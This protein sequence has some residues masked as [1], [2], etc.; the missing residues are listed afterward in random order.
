MLTSR[1]IHD[2][3]CTYPAT[4]QPPYNSP[5]SVFTPALWRLYIGRQR[6]NFVPYLCQLVLAAI[7]WVELL[8]MFVTLMSLKYALSAGWW[9]CGHFPQLIDY[10]LFEWHGKFSPINSTHHAK[11]YPQNGDRIAII[12]SVTS[13]YRTL[14]FN[15]N[16][17][18][19]ASLCVFLLPA[20]IFSYACSIVYFTFFVPL[21]LTPLRVRLLRA[22]SKNTQKWRFFSGAKCSR[23][24]QF[25]ATPANA[26]AWVCH[27]H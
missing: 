19:L 11:L 4:S 14:F 12:D 9:S 23:G 25:D 13:F 2:L 17:F 20:R 1:H 7:L 5:H 6:R 8:E 24:R 26:A 15:L 27:A 3:L 22:F 10:I 16:R 21:L 18:L